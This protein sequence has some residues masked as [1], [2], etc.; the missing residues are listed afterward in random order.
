MSIAW[1]MCFSPY[2]NPNIVVVVAIPN[3]RTSGNAAPIARKIL[4]QYY[5]IQREDAGQALPSLNT[6]AP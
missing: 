3:G 1:F 6:V 5:A 4:E 2:E